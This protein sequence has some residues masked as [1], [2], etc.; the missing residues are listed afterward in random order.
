MTDHA[1]S[2]ASP[3][4]PSFTDSS[5]RCQTV[6]VGNRRTSVRLEPEMWD[7]LNTI[8]RLSG[9]TLPKIL[10][11]VDLYRQQSSLTSA[12]RVFILHFYR[13]AAQHPA[14]PPRLWVDIALH[15][16]KPASLQ[17]RA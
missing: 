10:S 8:T 9:L 4:Q 1:S 6:R 12:V 13:A 5:L 16:A 11:D 15:G 17:R 2:P 7:A 3:R 14:E